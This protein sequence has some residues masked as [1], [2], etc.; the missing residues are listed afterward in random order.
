[1]MKRS[2]DE[3]DL[4]LERTKVWLEGK[5][6]RSRMEDKSRVVSRENGRHETASFW[7]SRSRDASGRALLRTCAWHLRT[8]ARQLFLECSRP[9]VVRL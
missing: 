8:N 2:D 9:R 1:M 6:Q 5:V 4:P 7:S 3:D